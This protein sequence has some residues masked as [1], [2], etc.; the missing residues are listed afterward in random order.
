MRGW[1]LRGYQRWGQQEANGP[2]RLR[3]REPCERSPSRAKAD[4]RPRLPGCISEM[5]GA[6][7]WA[8]RAADTSHRLP[9]P[10][11]S[12]PYLVLVVLFAAVSAV[13]AHFKGRSTAAWG[14][15]GG[16]FFLFAFP[17]LCFLPALDEDGNPEGTGSTA[18][19]VAAGILTAFALLFLLVLGA[20]AYFARIAGGA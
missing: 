2:A 16:A 10:S 19:A 6:D 3:V 20:S 13:L 18:G 7:S 17:I 14:L 8:R 1:R 4:W 15:C 5:P 12:P 9:M 11:F